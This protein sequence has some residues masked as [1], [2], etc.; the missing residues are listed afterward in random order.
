MDSTCKA[1]PEILIR[2]HG[3]FRMLRHAQGD[4]LEVVVDKLHEV[5]PHEPLS[6]IGR[7]SAELRVFGVLADA[8]DDL[9]D[10]VSIR[11]IAVQVELF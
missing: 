11:V 1:P 10:F 7:K 9:P 3:K 8:L 5:V 2:D 6:A 4:V